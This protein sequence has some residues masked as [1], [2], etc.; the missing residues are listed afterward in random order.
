MPG[1]T[2]RL[3]LERGLPRGGDRLGEAEGEGPVGGSDLSGE[4]CLQAPL[5]S[6]LPHEPMGHAHA[7]ARACTHAETHMHTQTLYFSWV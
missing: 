2:V 4:H 5:S 7:Q 3:H 6:V 1:L